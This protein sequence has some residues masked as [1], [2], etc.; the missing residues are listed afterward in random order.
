MTITAVG[1]QVDSCDPTKTVLVVG[2]T[3]GNDSILFSPVGNSGSIEV[4]INGVSQGIFVP[5][6]R[7]VA[8]GQAGNDDIQVAGSI[9]NSAWL[10]GGAGN[11]RLKGGAGN[12]VL[13]GGDGDDLIVGGDGRD[14]LIG[15]FGA[16]RLVGNA[17]D[18]I[19]I[20]GTTAHDANDAA[21]CAIM[22][23]WRR[24]DVNFATRVEHLKNGGGVNES[25]R[26]N[27]LTVHDDGAADVLTGSEGQDWFLFNQDGDGGDTDRATDMKTFESM[28]AE[29]I[30]FFTGP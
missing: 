7:V 15:G 23:E 14:L 8:F 12:D 16:D 30:D 3:T 26:V 5:T 19:L 1:L 17:A 20:A 18:D 4:T 2:G 24:P 10:F 6:G 29:D 25:F 11:D 9:T 13:I 22:R 21:L 27:D 28:F